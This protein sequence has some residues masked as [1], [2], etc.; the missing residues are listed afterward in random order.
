M[1]EEERREGSLVNE[2][3]NAA[4]AAMAAERK[5]AAV[6]ATARSAPPPPARTASLWP[7][8][9]SVEPACCAPLPALCSGERVSASEL[10][11]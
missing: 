6:R 10:T 11:L 4:H 3:M 5:E 2:S 8:V 9:A 1:R 7:A